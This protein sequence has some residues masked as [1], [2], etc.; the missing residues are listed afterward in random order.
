MLAQLAGRRA[1][2]E[3]WQATYKGVAAS[4]LSP[5]VW[6]T[7]LVFLSRRVGRRRAFALV[8]TSAVGALASIAWWERF[9]RWR[10]I[11][12]VERAEQ[13]HPADLAAAQLSRS[14][15]RARVETLVAEPRRTASG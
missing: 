7:E 9:V 10:R 5:I 11:R 1:K 8:A 15:V 3:L 4:L 13:E 6:T 2:D 12:W 14:E